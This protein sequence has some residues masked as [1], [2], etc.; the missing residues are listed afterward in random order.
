MCC[1]VWRGDDDDDVRPTT[2]AISPHLSNEATEHD[3]VMDHQQQLQQLRSR[4][5]NC[6]FGRVWT[7][8]FIRILLRQN[9][10][11]HGTQQTHEAEKTENCIALYAA[12]L[13]LNSNLS[14]PLTKAL[15]VVY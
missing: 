3:Y 4:L 5:S 12:P 7:T 15:N 10:E 11:P 8:E 14:P 1:L 2:E 9:L 13:P 6:A